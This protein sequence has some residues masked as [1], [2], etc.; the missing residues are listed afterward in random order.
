VTQDGALNVDKASEIYSLGRRQEPTNPTVMMAQSNLGSKSL[1][2]YS[3]VG[4]ASIREKY[5][6]WKDFEK[7]G[8]F[9]LFR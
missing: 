8:R 1:Q 3:R 2:G 6:A 7:V 5:A 9:V 4:R